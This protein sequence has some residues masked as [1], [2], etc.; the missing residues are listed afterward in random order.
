MV[1]L[2]RVIG[3]CVALLISGLAS[4]ADAQQIGITPLL[5]SYQELMALTPA[6]RAEYLEGFQKLLT[7]LAQLPSEQT[8]IAYREDI[9]YYLALIDAL[10][11]V[12]SAQAPPRTP[13]SEITL[14]GGC[15]N[16]HARA[17]M[18]E[19]T[20]LPMCTPSASA[21]APHRGECDPVTTVAVRDPAGGR[22]SGNTL[23]ASI[24]WVCA[25]LNSFWALGTTEKGRRA[26]KEM[27]T[28]PSNWGEAQTRNF[29]NPLFPTPEKI[30]AEA[31]ERSRAAAERLRQQFLENQRRIDGGDETVFKPETPVGPAG[32]TG[33]ELPPIAECKDR[34]AE[35]M[36]GDWQQEGGFC[37]NGGNISQFK[38]DRAKNRYMCTAVSR[39]CKTG[40]CAISNRAERGNPVLHRC[41]QGMAM[42]NPYVFG[43]T[44]IARELGAN[45]RPLTPA[46]LRQ[47]R[48]QANQT[49]QP[50]PQQNSVG[51]DGAPP[52]Q[53]PGTTPE[54]KFNLSRVKPICVHQRDVEITKRCEA[55][56]EKLKGRGAQGRYIAGKM[57]LENA[58]ESA[59]GV[60]ENWNQFRAAFNTI[61]NKS[62]E[63]VA[64]HCQE[65][66][67]IAKRL[68]E[69]NLAAKEGQCYLIK[70]GMDPKWRQAPQAAPQ[71]PA[72]ANQ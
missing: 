29:R 26:M 71:A 14:T 30:D 20:T 3:L 31:Q 44:G 10:M 60:P 46:Q 42:C 40:V 54:Q 58:D 34:N 22:R 21:A 33:C 4:K 70:D 47:Q 41:A 43:V 35:G 28:I 23:T 57:F 27:R 16:Q 12:A 13:E 53:E 39:F 1:R 64:F 17:F 9:N 61:C 66:N 68:H 24:G 49:T 51:T 38:F 7:E 56:A 18:F 6:K 69:M 11:P 45:G 65:C 19:G 32:T 25:T 2:F 62:R 67:I 50:P 37:I 55:E 5:L 15:G 59:R 8:S 48:Q 52:P 36:R 72:N 63:S